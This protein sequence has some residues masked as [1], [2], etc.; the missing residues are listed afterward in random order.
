MAAY[1]TKL[2]GMRDSGRPPGSNGLRP[3][4]VSKLP[5]IVG[6]CRNLVKQAR[7]ASWSE[8]AAARRRSCSDAQR[9][10][11]RLRRPGRRTP[12]DGRAA[13]DQPARRP[14]RSP[15]PL[16][17]GL[18]PRLPH[19]SSVPRPVEPAHLDLPHRREPGAQSPPVLAAAPS[20]RPGVARRARGAHGEFLSGG[21]S[22]PDR[23]LAQ[24]ELAGGF[25]TRSTACRSISGRRSCCGRS[26][27]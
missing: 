17:G 6:R 8:S 14:R 27:A 23:V 24:K 4:S 3:C 21:E 15:R 1:L 9:R 16:P 7:V 11:G 2:G 26:T 5:A 22:T 12:A 20:G 19:H 13:G 10:R 25:S 18:P